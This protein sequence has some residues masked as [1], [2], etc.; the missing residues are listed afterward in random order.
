MRRHDPITMLILAFVL[1]FA[2][3]ITWVIT[4]TLSLPRTDLAYGQMPFED[5]LVLP[6]MSIFASKVAKR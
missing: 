5:P 2:F 6:I 3:A 4:M 1:A